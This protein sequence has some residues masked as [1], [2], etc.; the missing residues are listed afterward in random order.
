[1]TG[2]VSGDLS[3]QEL[4]DLFQSK[5]GCMHSQHKANSAWRM[6]RNHLTS[7]QVGKVIT[8]WGHHRDVGLERTELDDV[9]DE[10]RRQWQESLS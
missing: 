7:K 8:A 6:L 3:R 1:M 9:C 5:A 10:I 2:L 4:L